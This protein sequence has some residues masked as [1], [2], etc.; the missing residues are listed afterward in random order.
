MTS[1]YWNEDLYSYSTDNLNSQTQGVVRYN[2]MSYAQTA[3]QSSISD[4]VARQGIIDKLDAIFVPKTKVEWQA[5][6]SDVGF[7]ALDAAN[8]SITNISSN[9]ALYNAMQIIAKGTA[10]TSFAASM[11]FAV[12]NSKDVPAQYAT[13]ELAKNVTSTL[14]GSVVGAGVYA[15]ALDGAFI[16]LGIAA[17]APVAAAVLAGLTAIAVGS[18]ASHYW[19]DITSGYFNTYQDI[20]NF[21][22]S[23]E[24]QLQSILD[25]TFQDPSFFSKLEEFIN[26]T[27]DYG[28]SNLHSLTD[29]IAQIVTKFSSAINASSPLVLDLDGDGIELSH[30]NQIGTVYWDGDVDGAREASAWVGPDDGLLVRDVNGNGTIDNNSELF[31]NNAT[32][33]NGFLN[34]KSLDSNSDNKITSADAQWGSLKVWKD[35][36]QDGIS[37]TNELYTLNALGISEIN[38]AY[39]NS[40]ATIAGNAIKQTSTFVQ[41]GITKT[42]VD[43]WFAVD[44]VNSVY[45]GTYTLNTATLFL[46]TLRGYGSLPDL[47]VAMSQNAALLTAVQTFTGKSL[48]T[49]IDPNSTAKA[50][51][52]AILYK[53]A[54]VDSIV[55]GSRGIY[56]NAKD[57]AFL[58]KLM[59]QSYVQI[60][61]SSNP[62]PNEFA[63]SELVDAINL[64]VDNFYARVVY[65]MGPGSSLFTVKPTYNPVTDAFEGAAT[66]N[67]TAIQAAFTGNSLKTWDLAKQWFTVFSIIDK[68]VDL[69]SLSTSDKSA[70]TAYVAS[71]DNTGH[72]TFAG[73]Q[74]AVNATGTSASTTG[75]DLLFG[76]DARNTIYGGSGHDILFG[77]GDADSLYGED[78]N[79]ILVGGSGNDTLIGGTGDDIYVV[80]SGADIIDEVS[81]GTGGGTDVLFIEGNYTISQITTQRNDFTNRNMDVYANGIKI[82]TVNDQFLNTTDSI[83]TIKLS[84]GSSI[85]LLGIQYTTNGTSSG[86]TIYG[87]NAGANTND[88]INGLGGSDSIYG[89]AG[90]D[91]IT[92]GTGDDYLY[93]GVGNDTYV[94]ATG[95]G[96]DS[97]WEEGGTDTLEFTSSAF[98]AANMTKIQYG[99]DLRLYFGGTHTLTLTQYFVLDREIETIKF[100]DGTTYNLSADIYTLLG[101]ASADT[102]I[103]NSGRI[104]DYIYGYGGNDTI[105]SYAGND[106]LYGGDGSDTLMAGDGDDQLYGE[107]D[108]DILYGEAGNDILDGGLGLDELKGGAGDDTYIIRFNQ[109]LDT[110]T[111]TDGTDTIQFTGNTAW[112]QSNFSASINGTYVDFSFSGTVVAKA[113]LGYNLGYSIEILKFNDNT[114]LDFANYLWVKQ[115]TASGET[116][117]GNTGLADHLIG[118]GGNDTLYG[119]EGND[120]LNGGAGTD[121]LIGGLGA[122]RFVF[123]TTTL[124]S[125]DTITDFSTAQGDKLDISQIL[126]GYDPLTSLIDN[127]ISFTTSGSNTNVFVDRDGTGSAYTAQ[128]IATL[129]GV[130]GLDA[131]VMLANGNLI[132]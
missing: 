41:N 54:G 117:T 85:D 115:G 79:D 118:L 8:A 2:I 96:L 88:I 109:G 104:I 37:Q 59:G 4:S 129:T 70:L 78:G 131:D 5:L 30:L 122:D 62:N 33:A 50:D 15:A 64:A 49:L 12:E 100:S 72:I 31:G 27:V 36:N 40:A 99:Q 82:A 91:R 14:M 101:T 32:Y 3:A 26:D 112:T 11:Y 86:D 107:N 16:G 84:N 113:Y 92:G 66:L 22:S 74:A 61:N 53:W 89:Y 130:T 105:W 51:F 55:D 48:A 97:I 29:Y 71:T 127:F 1:T 108:N 23:V 111:E 60:N 7:T 52:K 102:L 57:L 124:G 83:E 6:A 67:M 103:V 98:T 56:V 121:T 106:R 17:S 25:A 47:H 46:P 76:N 132:A 34:L 110:I 81:S 24:N 120:V 80:G 125:V 42:I 13:Y 93:G 38:L 126:S 68:A 35:T 77:N 75:A 73:L 19:D 128:A 114:T 87:T 119:Y 69:A 39:S 90:N 21:I 116:L 95:D 28:G 63:A 58:E 18:L 65:Q 43:A 9:P 44:Q 94:Y 10:A 20:D 123:D 45:D